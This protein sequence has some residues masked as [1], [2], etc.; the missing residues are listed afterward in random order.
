M[1]L[2]STSRKILPCDESD[3]ANRVCKYF[4][5][6]IAVFSHRV[7]SYNYSEYNGIVIFTLLIVV[8]LLF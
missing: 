6:S 8:K 1:L 7:C 2:G 4:T 3:V 5:L